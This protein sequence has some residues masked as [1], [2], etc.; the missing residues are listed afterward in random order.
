[1]A[2]VRG[3]VSQSSDSAAADSEARAHAS[4]QQNKRSKK[5]TK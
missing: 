5:T 1:M 2:K 4:K 3:R